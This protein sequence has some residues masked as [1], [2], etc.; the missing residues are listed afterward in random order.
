MSATLAPPPH[1]EHVPAAGLLRLTC[2]CWSTKKQKHTIFNI[3]SNTCSCFW[4]SSS[5]TLSLFGVSVVEIMGG[6]WR[7][8]GRRFWCF[9]TS[10]NYVFVWVSW[11]M[12]ERK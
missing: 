8:G 3:I 7:E 5:D 12:P 4:F 10:M 1:R 6:G 9:L 2:R 11:L